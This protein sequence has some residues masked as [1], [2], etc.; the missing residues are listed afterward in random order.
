[1]IYS[2]LISLSSF[3]FFIENLSKYFFLKYCFYKFE[4]PYKLFYKQIASYLSCHF[5]Y[6]KISE[7][8]LRYFR[9]IRVTL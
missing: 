4:K 2:P 7:M 6:N 9:N 8:D 3:P 1:M 5:N